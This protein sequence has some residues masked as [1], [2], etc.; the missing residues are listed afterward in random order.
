VP[1]RGDWTKVRRTTSL[2]WEDGLGAGTR[3]RAADLD[4]DRMFTR[5]PMENTPY[6][7]LRVELGKVGPGVRTYVVKITLNRPDRLAQESIEAEDLTTLERLLAHLG[8]EKES[9]SFIRSY[10]FT[11]AWEETTPLSA[12]DAANRMKTS[13]F[14]GS[15]LTDHVTS[16][17]LFERIQAWRRLNGG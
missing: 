5:P 6:R 15:L 4:G 8:V 14:S 12:V 13:E 9:V 1:L 3:N 16:D 7:R 17:Q 10:D 2:I 11:R